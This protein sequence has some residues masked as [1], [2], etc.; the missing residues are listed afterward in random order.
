M[1]VDRDVAAFVSAA[2]V[3]SAAPAARRQPIVQPKL[4][5]GKGADLYMEPT[6][7]FIRNIPSFAQ[8]GCSQSTNGWVGG[9]SSELRG[10]QGSR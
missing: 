5:V 10:T 1:Q 3:S 2:T 9:Y 6:T 7:L 4:V 8:V